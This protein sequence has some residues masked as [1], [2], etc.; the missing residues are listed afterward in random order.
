MQSRSYPTSSINKTNHEQLPSSLKHVEKRVYGVAEEPRGALRGLT[1]RF[2]LDLGLIALIRPFQLSLLNPV[3]QSHG[4]YLKLISLA[5][6]NQSVVVGLV[7]LLFQSLGLAMTEY[8]AGIFE[9]LSMH[10]GTL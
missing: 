1:I 4:R 3:T 10:G 9:F 2:D 6:E 8:T 5:S 7:D